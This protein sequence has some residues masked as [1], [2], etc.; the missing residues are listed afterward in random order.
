MQSQSRGAQQISDA[1]GQLTEA[2]RHTLESLADFNQATERMRESVQSMG[3]GISQFRAGET[4][5]AHTDPGGDR[6]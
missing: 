1:M 3:R 5:H 2:T 6:A 4:D